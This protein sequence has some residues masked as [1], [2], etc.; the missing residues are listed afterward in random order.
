MFF[1][2]FQNEILIKKLL[3]DLYGEDISLRPLSGGT[4]NLNYVM[5]ERVVVRIL[6]LPQTSLLFSEA[7]SYLQREIQ[8][9]NALR[10]EGLNDFAYLPFQDGEWIFSL[11][12]NK[13]TI[14][15]MQSVYL[16]G[17]IVSFEKNIIPQI[18]QKIVRFHDFSK[19]NFTEYQRIPV[20][21]DLVSSLHIR[22]L[23]YE[24][25]LEKDIPNYKDYWELFQ[26]NTSILKKAKQA[27]SAFFIH[28]DLHADNILFHKGKLNILDF[29][30][31]RYSLPE[32]DIGT[33][34]WGLSLKTNVASFTELANL[35]FANYTREI[36]P[37]LCYRFALQRFLEIHL[38]Y[39]V[40][41]QKNSTLMKYQ[42][43]KFTKEKAM[44][45]YLSNHISFRN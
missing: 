13:G 6:Y 31:A 10:E 7:E 9:A 38:F 30:D 17:E 12:V 19:E 27:Q 34:L 22:S 33:F 11:S 45:D 14:Y 18:A 29:G 1:Q 26:I 8:F 44:I 41:N 36:N 35:F 23:S 3:R 15:V 16:K 24:K 4:E 28:N 2:P 32:E 40:E 20:Y 21:D 39:L 37:E 5:N 42:K 43:A 25:E